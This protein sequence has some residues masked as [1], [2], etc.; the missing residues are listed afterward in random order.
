MLLINMSNR[1]DRW[2][3]RMPP[4]L[5]PTALDPADEPGRPQ[6][7]AGA[8]LWLL[9][10]YARDGGCERLHH[11][12]SRH[13]A[14]LAEHPQAEPALR[15]TCALLLEQWDAA[16]PPAGPGAGPERPGGGLLERL[17]RLLQ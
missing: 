7:L 8:T 3:P 6:L 5:R 10:R 13:L 4:A 9:V 11:V 12:V 15:D 2:S 17:G 16:P 14:L 1:L